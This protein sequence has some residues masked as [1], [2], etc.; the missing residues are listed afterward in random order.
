MNWRPAKVPKLRRQKRKNHGRLRL[1]TASERMLGPL[2]TADTMS[3]VGADTSWVLEVFF[4]EE[5]L[6][7]VMARSGLASRRHC[8]EWILQGRVKV[9]G[10]TC[11]VLG[12]KVDP[13][14]DDITVDGKPLSGRE[15]KV[16]LVFHKPKD[17]I[18]TLHDEQDRPTIMRYLKSIQQ[19]VYPVGRLDG[20]SEGLLFLTNDGELAHRLMHPSYG[21]PKTYRVWLTGHISD[22]ALQELADGVE[23]EDGPTGPA[24]V[25]VR[26]NQGHA[27][28]DMTIHEGRNRQVRRMCSAVGHEVKRL[29]RISF[30]PLRLGD[31]AVGRYR[32]LDAAEKRA[33][34]EV[35]GY[36]S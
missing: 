29:Q 28:L 22:R 14:R 17:V 3:V 20:D 11:R 8:E 18:T 4:V 9:N 36:D 30:G 2:P 16:Y 25:Q 31:L 7:K 26:R 24:Q 23:L 33:L 34:F 35:V 5:R 15:E 6:Q 12:T 1:T 32:R 13:L 19:R 27:I 10:R 21:V